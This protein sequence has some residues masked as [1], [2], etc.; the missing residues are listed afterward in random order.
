MI[1]ASDIKTLFEIEPKDISL[2]KSAFIHKSAIEDVCMASYE[3]LEFVGDSV[4]NMITAKFLYE[5]FPHENE[6]F[7]TRARTKIV[8]T[9][10]LSSIAKKLKL[11]D[12][13][14]MD[15]KGLANKWNENDKI[16]ED[17]LEAIIGA[18]FVDL[19]YEIAEQVFTNMIEKYVDWDILLN[20]NYKEKLNAYMK[21]NN[22]QKVE[23]NI[24]KRE[25]N[26]Y[27]VQLII[28]GNNLSEG[29]H[30]QKKQAEQIAA[31]RVLKSL[32]IV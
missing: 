17:V 15:A 20:T 3:R 6:G 21:D 16:Q 8:C 9:Q 25:N 24:L 32:Q 14:E 12:K 5:K 28:D 7:M 31:H 18:I 30:K 19:G 13:I 22:L 27:V 2:Y 29:I 11:S 23:Y 1:E 26:D 4:I 10:G